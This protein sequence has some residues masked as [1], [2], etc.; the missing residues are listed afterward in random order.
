MGSKDEGLF[1]ITIFAIPIAK[2]DLA[3]LDFEDAVVGER[4]AVG[5]AAEIVKN[6]T[7]RTE[8]LFRKD[9]PILLA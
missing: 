3:V 1:P 7:G 6:S 9:N 4:H 8:G 5:V 2:G